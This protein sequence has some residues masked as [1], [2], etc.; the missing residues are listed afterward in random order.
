MPLMSSDQ[1]TKLREYMESQPMLKHDVK[2]T[3]E[4]C[5][6]ENNYNLEGLQDFF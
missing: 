4:K 2:F 1:F 6:T 5:G 3:C